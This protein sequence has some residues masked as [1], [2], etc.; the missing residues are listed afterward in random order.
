MT[1]PTVTRNRRHTPVL[2]KTKDIITILSALGSATVL[3][4]WSLG[5]DW[6]TPAAWIRRN[7]AASNARLTNV[8][9]RVARVENGQKETNDL[10]EI[11]ARDACSRFSPA[12][13]R[14]A[15]KCDS[16]LPPPPRR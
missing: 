7:E 3:I 15:P 10:L 8:E 14:V 9:V 11:V 13:L 2:T 12:Q 16:L 1:A 5:F 6:Q 4:F